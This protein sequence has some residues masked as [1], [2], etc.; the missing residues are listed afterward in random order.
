MEEVTVDVLIENQDED[1]PKQDSN[2]ETT[3]KALN[4]TEL[5]E[6]LSEYGI[7][8]GPILP[9]TRTIYEKKLLQFM[10]ECPARAAGQK[11]CDC[12][13][14]EGKDSEQGTTTTK[15]VLEADNL[16]A[17]AECPSGADNKSNID[18]AE[19]QKKLLS[20][21]VEYSL[22][23]I[24]AELQEILPEG[25]VAAYRSQGQR[26]KASRS[27]DK[28][29]RPMKSDLPREDYGYPEAGTG[30]SV[31]RR[32][33]KENP[34]PVKKGSESK[35]QVMPESPD[36][37]FIPTRVKMAVFAIFVFI[38]FVYVTMETNPDNPFIA[39]ITGK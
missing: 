2:D 17:A 38:L 20:P 26:K 32:T 34:L 36:E 14:E 11:W 12:V 27:P 33:I 3:V 31:R 25:K 10:K 9:S 24:V 19:K 7:S 13:S 15:V 21:D 28:N 16:K 37:G 39:F 23:K 5:R 35:S 30:Q 29:Q 22:A 1:S 18:M 4:D 6:Q 8:P